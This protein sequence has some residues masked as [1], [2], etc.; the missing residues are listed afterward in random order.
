ML[1][2]S[3]VG[4]AQTTITDNK[5]TEEK[6][7]KNKKYKKDWKYKK[8]WKKKKYWKDKKDWKDKSHEDILKHKMRTLDIDKDGK[9][10]KEE[11]SKS[12]YKKL[13]E[14]FNFFDKNGDGFIDQ[15]ELYNKFKNKKKGK[16]K[17]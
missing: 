5:N 10:S 2:C 8:N 7:W 14:K 9:I 17:K 12:D 3:A 13:D 6:T 15:E 1:F 4:I 11:A 16:S